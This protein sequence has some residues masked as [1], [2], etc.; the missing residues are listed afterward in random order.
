MAC[1]SYVSR[2]K[3]FLVLN[4][5]T[6]RHQFI[7]NKKIHVA[8]GLAVEPISSS[9]H[10]YKVVC[11]RKL[12]R[13]D[14]Y[15]FEIFSSD[16]LSWRKSSTKFTSKSY[17]FSDALPIYSHGS[18]HWI[19]KCNDILAFHVKKRE[20][21]IIELPRNLPLPFVNWTSWFGVV[22]GLLTIISTSREEI[23]VWILSDYKNVE[24]VLKTRITN[25]LNSEWSIRIPSFYDGERLVMLQR[26]LGE[27]GEVGMY[28][29]AT[30]KWRKIGMSCRALDRNRA[31]VPFVP[32]LAEIK[33][34]MWPDVPTPVV[35]SIDNL[36]LLVSF[37]GSDSA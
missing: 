6:K 2:K 21:R 5:V 37:K 19:R 4:P 16:I 17:N 9:L 28:D 13:D 24:W 34:R 29:I 25:I 8:I 7:E 18:L 10:R 15:Q 3:S 22:N 27:D 20:A 14:T 33:T 35:Q 36:S 26:K 30:D 32:S 23:S 11:I 31:F 1:F 12:P